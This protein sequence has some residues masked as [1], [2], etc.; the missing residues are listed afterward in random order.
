MPLSTP[1]PAGEYRPDAPY[2][3]T[4]GGAVRVFDMSA[5]PWQAT[6]EPGL[7]LKPVREDSG[8]GHYLGLVQFEANCRS[9]VHQ[10]QGVATSFVVD[11]GLTDYYGSLRLH[12]VG[13]NIRGSTH[14]AI[15]YQRTVLVSRLE[16]RV[17]YPPDR[18]IS[19]VHS[20]SFAQT[21]ENPDPSVPPERN[22]AIDDLSWVETGVPGV[23]VQ[24]IFDYALTGLP[25]RMLQWSVRPQ[26][27]FGFTA[28]A[29]TECW[30]RGGEIIVNGQSAYGNCFV[31]CEAGA[32]VDI[33]SPFGALILV[34]AEGA[35]EGAP[36]ALCTY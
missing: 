29:L 11:G 30:V 28:T 25:H 35:P 7:W 4:Q 31:V 19:G 3:L 32:R 36:R 10:H 21:F 2:T 27:R 16:G 33:S 23:R 8:K 12:Q 14:D 17:S 13:I 26:T 9:G 15:A 18:S 6:A 1:L 34:W 22:I 24:A 20:G 5:F